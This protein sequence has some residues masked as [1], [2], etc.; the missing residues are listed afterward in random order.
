MA[1]RRGL[2]ELNIHDESLAAQKFDRHGGVLAEN[3]R[4]DQVW[5]KG[6]IEF[7]KK[8]RDSTAHISPEQVFDFSFIR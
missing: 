5:M 4:A 2:V 1:N 8:S 3:R 7:A 6:A